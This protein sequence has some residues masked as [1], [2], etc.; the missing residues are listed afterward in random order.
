MKRSQLKEMI[1][2]ELDSYNTNLTPLQL[3]QFMI[4]LDTYMLP[5]HTL[6]VFGV[7]D[8]GYEKEDN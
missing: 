6:N 4:L 2:K 8:L 3:E 5:K 1:K 7:H